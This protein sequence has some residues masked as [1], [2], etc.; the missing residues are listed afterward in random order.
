M[1]T[2]AVGELRSDERLSLLFYC[3]DSPQLCPNAQTALVAALSDHF[4]VVVLGGAEP[5]RRFNPLRPVEVVHLPAAASPAAHAQ[6]QRHV[7]ATY[8]AVD[9]AIV[10][11]EQFPFCGTHLAGEIVPLLHAAEA[12]P[13]TCL[14]AG[15][16]MNMLVD[17]PDTPERRDDEWHQLADRY[18]DVIFVHADARLGRVEEKFLGGPPLRV[19]FHY[20]GFIAPERV[21][22]AGRVQNRRREIIVSCDGHAGIAL[23]RAALDAYDHFPADERSPLRIVVDASRAGGDADAPRSLPA[24]RHG[25]LV[26]RKMPRHRAVLAHTALFVGHA[27]NTAVEMLHLGVPVLV[28][29]RAGEPPQCAAWAR[30]LAAAG[31]IRLLEHDR[32]DGPL[33]ARQM[34][35][36]LKLPPPY[37][38]LDRSGTAETLRFVARLS[39]PAHVL[40][41]PPAIDVESV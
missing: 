2:P 6:R 18:F 5:S 33:L 28:V 19:P 14:V 30:R 21:G 11:V 37:M 23:L 17:A 35:S 39:D 36:T 26:Q 29:P 8:R 4:R 20:T 41:V 1:F 32:V 40:A 16:V 13:R 7:M 25:V 34:A 12:N 22:H 38:S 31:A 24:R 3:Q 27:G 15:S 9:P 10:L